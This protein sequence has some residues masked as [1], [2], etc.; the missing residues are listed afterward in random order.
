MWNRGEENSYFE[1]KSAVDG[2]QMSIN[3]YN[4]MKENPDTYEV[5]LVNRENGSISRHKFY[6]LDKFKRINEYL[7]QFKQTEEK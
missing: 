3:E 5:V 7:F 1:I 6:E 4:S 2:F